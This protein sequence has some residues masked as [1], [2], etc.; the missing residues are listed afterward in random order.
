MTAPD[1]TLD[2]AGPR[3]RLWLDQLDLMEAMLAPITAP[4]ITALALGGGDRVADIGCGGGETT[5]AIAAAGAEADGYDISVDLVAE[6]SRRYPALRFEQADAGRHRPATRY[7]RLASRFGTMFFDDPP[8]AFA[9]LARWLGPGGTLAFAVWGP[10]PEVVFMASVRAAVAAEMDVPAS[11]PDAPGPCR[12]GDVGKLIALLG[13]A[14]LQ[15]ATSETWR[16]QLTVGGG[17]AADAAADF[18]LSISSAG[19]AAADADAETRARIL[20]R[21]AA[22]CGDHIEGGVVRMPARVEIVTARA[23]A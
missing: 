12:Y 6:A 18:L 17:M 11:D 13:G 23:P 21:L 8:A 2:W 10:A 1:P 5:L 15:D 19:A 16:G 20:R 9:N 14:G 7:D 22:T 4:M 3:G